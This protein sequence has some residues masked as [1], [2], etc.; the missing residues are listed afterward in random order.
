MSKQGEATKVKDKFLIIV[1]Y[2]FNQIQ[3]IT[4]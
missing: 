3:N 4:G 2:I 1:I